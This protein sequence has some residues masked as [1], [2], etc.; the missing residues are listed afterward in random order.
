[1]ELQIQIKMNE[2]L[3]LRDPEHTELGKN[4]ILH[5]IKMIYKLGFESFTFRK[6]ALDIGTTEAGIYRYF[7]NKHR[8]LVYIIAWYWSWLEYRVKI[9]TYNIYNPEERLRIVLKLLATTVED[10]I[11][12]S[13][14]NESILHQIIIAESTKAFMTNHVTDDN[15]D[16]LFK[17]YKD[18][19]KAIGDFILACNPNYKYPKSLA[20]SIIEIA[21][22]QN[23]FMHNLPALTDFADEK[24]E[25]KILEFLEDLVFASIGKY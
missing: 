13:H 19:C 7:E 4:I 23:F 18:L 8:L 10:D 17:P 21:H 5:S 12:T 24:D 20:N 25:S 1:M 2:K 6:L 14:V 16:Q 9:H 22:L 11:Q 15:K 3:Y